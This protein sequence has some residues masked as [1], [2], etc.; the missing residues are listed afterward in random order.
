M[1]VYLATRG[2]QDYFLTER[3]DFTFFNKTYAQDLNHKTTITNVPFDS[4]GGSI[5]T[6]PMNGDYISDITLKV[7]LDPTLQ[8][9]TSWKFE[10][11]VPLGNISFYTIDYSALLYKIDYS[12]YLQFVD[13]DSFNFTSIV[14]NLQG[15]AIIFDNI[16]IAN[17]YGFSL[18]LTQL[19]G[20]Y[21]SY[22]NTN[23]SSP[24]F[25]FS[26]LTLPE[27]G[28]VNN[29]T[30]STFYIPQDLVIDSM[31][32]IYVADSGN[33]V[34]RK[35]GPGPNYQT[36]T[37]AGIAGA[38]GSTDGPGSSALFNNPQ[39]ITID[40]L[41]NLYVSDTLNSTIRMIGPGPDYMVS[42]IAGTVGTPGS[43]DSPA[44]FNEPA[45]LD[46]DSFGNLYV[47]DTNNCT[48]RMIG[49]GPAY[50]VTTIAGTAGT[51]G[52]TDSPAL[53]NLPA[54][55]KIDNTGNI[56][57]AD[58]YNHT[59]RKIGP[60]PAYTVTTIAGTA[61][62][63]GSTD[64]P[65]SSALFNKPYGASVD[66]FGNIYVADSGNSTIRKIGPDPTYTVT[67][68]AGLPK[69][70]GT[71]DGPSSRSLFTIPYAA[72]FDKISGNI[73]V[74]DTGSSCIRLIT[75][76]TSQVDTIAGSNS[77]SSFK[78]GPALESS[79]DHPLGLTCDTVSDNLYVVD[80][81]NSI[82]RMIGPGPAYIVTTIAGIHGLNGSKDGIGSSAL[83]NSPYGIVYD[84][85]STNLYVADSGNST[86]RKIGPGPAYTVTTIAG[87]AGTTGSTD[88]PGASALF[89]N[90]VGIT[91][92][93]SGNLYVTDSDNLTVR[94]IG[95]GPNYTVT[96]LLGTAYSLQSP[97]GILSYG[98]DIYLTDIYAP[99]VNKWDG[100]NLT[101]LS[102][103]FTNV[104]GVPSFLS[105]TGVT[106]DSS[107]NLIYV[108]DIGFSC[109]FVADLTSL[110][111]IGVIGTPVSLG[112]RDGPV[113]LGAPPLPD[114]PL[115][116][117]PFSGTIDAYG[118]VYILDSGNSVLRKWDLATVSIFAGTPIVP[119]ALDPI[120]NY[121]DDTMY[122]YINSISLSIGKQVIQQ[123]PGGYL[124]MKRDISS[125]Y[126]NRP[127]LKLLEGDT[128]IS[129]NDRIY[130]L[131]T[132]LINNIPMHLLANQDVQVIVDTKIKRKSLII[133]YV[134]FANTKL[135]LEYTLIVPQVQT[136]HGS[137]EIDI[138]SPIN[139]LMSDS[140]FEFSVNGE[141]LFDSDT[142][143]VSQFDN[144]LNISSGYINVFRG[145]MNMSRI[146]T[147]N[148]NGP[149][150]DSNIW[151]ETFNVLKIQNGLSG[152]VFES[153]FY[154][155]G[156]PSSYLIS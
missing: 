43:T 83:F 110:V 68:I 145:P 140:P 48:I 92:D 95:P 57:V 126:K 49:P 44:L 54:D 53:F 105:P 72:R 125:T 131:K 135:P 29:I 79:F 115:F 13:K 124:K 96:T 75:L 136:F 46:F 5:A 76:S 112:S 113:T 128:N 21:Y 38:T 32:N 116:T 42:T 137:G 103:D 64:G 99:S 141:K 120:T 47:A 97:C 108:F 63:I 20:G 14:K 62:N 37:I 89:N 2:M 27:C 78:D 149:V 109:I 8:T 119:G 4:G 80:T 101:T 152:L 39:G 114:G 117:I 118:N 84:P 19:L 130:F 82:I 26:P 129:A 65:G 12:Y 34:I 139:K 122:Y 16:N 1:S 155:F 132:G 9:Q 73:F 56:Y 40:S 6:L 41:G 133:D 59:I 25:G 87:T 102:F 107:N 55:V 51:P 7:T 98:T 61:G 67:T 22:T 10:G 156:A 151:A 104:P 134:S 36:Q 58:T 11:D 138:K 33:S 17:Y 85:V 100:T 146:R 93:S 74:A 70:I 3:P 31:G 123:L 81:N 30:Q 71:S 66:P 23:T 35:I 45:G 121:P 90:P 50:T 88:G 111:I 147:K 154:S 28:W 60:G 18:G 91:I 86:I 153:S 150:P 69:K 144:L 77:H 143:N 106:I 24:K 15:Y 52:S 127:V 142:S 148:I 94:Q